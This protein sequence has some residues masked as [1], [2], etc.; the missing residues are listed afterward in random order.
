MSNID[1]D[2]LYIQGHPELTLVALVDEQGRIVPVV[3]QENG[4][5][6]Q[7]GDADQ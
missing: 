5:E 3:T 1:P 2:T 4:Q 6:T 7:E